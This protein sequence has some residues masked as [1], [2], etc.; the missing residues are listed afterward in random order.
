MLSVTDLLTLTKKPKR[1][2]LSLLTIQ[3]FYKEH[4]CDRLFIFETDNVERPVIKLR[5]KE[6]H[7]CHLLGLHYI[8]DEKRHGTAYI[9]DEGYNLIKNGTLTFEFI[10]QID[11]NALSKNENRILFFPFTY[12]ILQN[13][14]SIV[15]LPETV[16]FKSQLKVDLIF[17]N[18]LNNRYIHLGLDR[19][20]NRPQNYFPKSFFDRR[21]TN[22]IDG[23]KEMNIISI[24]TLKEYRHS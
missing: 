5:F 11:K 15:F 9:G 18:R 22:F 13:P 7:L 20:K 3:Q 2:F 4:L 6:E 23:Q 12:Q 14:T 24:K 10:E 17:Y 16:P 21:D 8:F 1:K 19:F